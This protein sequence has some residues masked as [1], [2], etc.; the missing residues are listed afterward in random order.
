MKLVEKRIKKIDNNPRA[1]GEKIQ[2]KLKKVSDKNPG[3]DI[4]YKINQVLKRED[5]E[6]L[7]QIAN[8]DN[9]FQVNKALI[10]KFK[11]AVIMSTDVERSFSAYKQVLSDKKHNLTMSSLEQ[12]MIVYCKKNYVQ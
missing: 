8:S 12:I 9:N 6:N 5:N 11:F 7:T 4:L 10:S 3:Y 2:L 1:F